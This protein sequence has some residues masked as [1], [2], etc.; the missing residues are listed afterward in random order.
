MSFFLIFSSTTKL[1][2]NNILGPRPQTNDVSTV[3]SV[4][5]KEVLPSLLMTHILC[6]VTG[7]SL[8]N[9]SLKNDISL[10]NTIFMPRHKKWRGIMLYPPNF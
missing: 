2:R 3:L 6:N 10:Q 5:I 9:R 4:G 1:P 7:E 8:E